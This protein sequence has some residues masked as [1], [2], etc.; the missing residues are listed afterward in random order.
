[1]QNHFWNIES[2]NYSLDPSAAP[3]SQFL[4]THKHTVTSETD[5]VVSLS[6]MS[7]EDAEEAVSVK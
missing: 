2:A 6:F 5:V 1:M 7:I 4:Y 3:Q